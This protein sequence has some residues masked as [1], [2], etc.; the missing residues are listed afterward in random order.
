MIRWI[1]LLAA[2]AAVTP[3][4]AQDADPAVTRLVALYDEI[5]LRT[6]PD[7]AAVDALMEAKRATPLTPEE[8]RV[9]FHNDPGRGWL[10]QDNGH[11]IQVMLELPPYH[12]CSVR[13]WTAAGFGDLTA[14]ADVTEA[15]KATRPG[16]AAVD[17][18]QADFDGYH[19]HM[20]GELRELADGGAET[21]YLFDQEYLDPARAAET[22]VP[23]NIR[24]VHQIVSPGAE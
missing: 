15:F 4:G 9:T 1:P 8:V 14:Y 11:N 13:R 16:F 20:S 7:D 3:A 10:L 22:E 12:A 6:F 5:C 19:I 17:E 21:L 18:Q 2:A 24:F 23:F